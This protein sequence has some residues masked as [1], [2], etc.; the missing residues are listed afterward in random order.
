MG[1]SVNACVCTCVRVRVYGEYGSPDTPVIASRT[2]RLVLSLHKVGARGEEGDAPSLRRN[3]LPSSF[4]TNHHTLLPCGLI[5]RDKKGTLGRLN[6][7]P[8]TT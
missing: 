8:H 5:S 7:P 6:L 4:E 1:K 2:D 3:K